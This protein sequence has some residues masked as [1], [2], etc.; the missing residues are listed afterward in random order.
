MA[1]FVERSS[2]DL[3]HC[4]GFRW[5]DCQTKTKNLSLLSRQSENCLS[6][7][8]ITEVGR[9]SVAAQCMRSVIIN[10]ERGDGHRI[11]PKRTG[12]QPCNLKEL[13]T[14]R[15]DL[16]ELRE[17]ISSGLSQNCRNISLVLFEVTE[18]SE[19]PSKLTACL[20]G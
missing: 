17:D 20:S 10:S 7:G 1:S 14:N 16:L 8:N 4:D 9:V 18:L 15:Q 11:S 3:R 13:M 19:A 2:K 6:L 5:S 12:G